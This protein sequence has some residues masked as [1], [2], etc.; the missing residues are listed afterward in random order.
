MSILIRTAMAALVF[1]VCRA[2]ILSA[3]VFLRRISVADG[4]PGN[5]VNVMAQDDK[6]FIWFGTTGGV[7]RYDGYSAVTPHSYGLG[8]IDMNV[9][10][11][12]VSPDNRH[13]S[14]WIKTAGGINLCYDTGRSGFVDYTGRGD[15]DKP[16]A[17]HV[18]VSDGVWLFGSGNGARHVQCRDGDFRVTDYSA[19]G[20]G[21]ADNDVIRVVEDN[22]RNMYVITRRGVTAVT[23]T[24]KTVSLL[25]GKEI[26]AGNS[27]GQKTFFLTSDARFYCYDTHLRLTGKSDMRELARKEI[28][29]TAD[30]VWNG[31]WLVFTKSRTLSV[32]L[33]TGRCAFARNMFQIPGGM[34]CKSAGGYRFVYDRHSDIL[35]FGSGGEFDRV[36]LPQQE[37]GNSQTVGRRVKIAR[38]SNGKFYIATNGDGLYVYEPSEKRLVHHTAR[39]GGSA[40]LSNTLLS[41]MA[42]TDGTVWIGNE[43]AG[44]TCVPSGRKEI[45]TRIRVP[46]HRDNAGAHNLIRYIGKDGN[47][48]FIASGKDNILYSLSLD[49]LKL[50]MT[51]RTKACVYARLKDKYGHVFTG[52]R[53]DGLYVDGVRY[54][55][56]SKGHMIAS[57]HIYD[58]RQ[59]A[60]GRIWIATWGG[61][62]LMT[63]YRNGSPLVFDTF[64][65]G[66]KLRRL[67]IGNDGRMWIAAT[68]GLY[69]ADVSDKVIAGN[70]FR[71][72]S[73][74]DGTFPIND[75]VCVHVSPG[76]AVYAGGV[77]RGLV[78]GILSGAGGGMS[79]TV[80]T[81]ADGLAD[82]NVRSV[83]EDKMGYIWA[84]TE[85]ALSRINMCDS[86]VVN[87]V[88]EGDFA[89]NSY[90]ENAV[91]ADADGRLLFGTGNG[92][93]VV[94]PSDI[95]DSRPAMIPRITN[96]IVNG[97]SVY[98]DGKLSGLLRADGDGQRLVLTHEQNSV[99]LS[100][101]DL[102]YGRS[103][104]LYMYRLDGVDKDWQLAGRI[105][106][107]QYSGLR[108]GR[109]TFLVRS[110]TGDSRW[111][112]ASVL[113]ITVRRPWWSSWW[114]FTLYALSGSSLLAWLYALWLRGY[115]LRRQMSEERRMTEFR[116]GLFTQIA[117]E[118]RTPLALIQGASARLLGLGGSDAT[119]QAVQTVRRGTARLLRQVNQLMEFR[120]V[121]AGSVRLSVSRGDIVRFV[122]D[123]ADDFRAEASGKGVTLSFVALSR[124]HSALFDRRVVETVAYNLLSNAVKYTPSGGSVTVR[125][126]S[127][128]GSLVLSV[129]DS[130][131]GLTPQ[132]RESLFTPFM[133][134]CVSG[135]GMGIGLYT[136]R[137][138]AEAHHGTLSYSAAPGG[139]SV[140]SMAFPAS[141]GAYAP[142]EVSA[143]P[144]AAVPPG[145]SPAVSAAR[146]EDI[147]GM[148]PRPLNGLTVA[149]VEDDPD[150]AAQLRSE[151]GVYFRTVCYSDGP[152]AAA[153]LASD[154]P[155]LVICDVMLPGLDGYG[156]VRSL[157]SSPA[158]RCVPVIMLTSL[159]DDAHQM[160]AYRAGADDYMV[161]P[162]NFG[163]LLAK[164][165]RLI[166]WAER[167]RGVGDGAPERPAGAVVT[168][169]A[170]RKF[171]ESVDNA[172][173][174]NL[175]NPDFSLDIL[176]EDMGMGR[177]KFYG[178]MKEVYGIPP[179]SYLAEYRLT[180]ARKMLDGG[181]M[182]PT[183]VSRKAGFRS[184]S[185]FSQR[186]RNRFGMSPTDYIS[187][188]GGDA[189]N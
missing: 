151:A 34:E 39:S 113:E 90:V 104:S 80:M 141:D 182:K 99:G 134:G 109:Y 77:G 24:G 142:S 165:V 122:R 132:Q 64:L 145:G 184:Y 29:Y 42:S 148:M 62:L 65:S 22:R 23:G 82:N 57:D 56:R 86:S 185:Y 51:M 27:D 98:E 17:N 69:L 31:Q 171:A 54:S 93:A 125:L 32:E 100:F 6:G 177:T 79:T 170:D 159:D 44:V 33:A 46:E 121:S 71:R 11:T 106:H 138:M 97:S 108:P 9:S 53:G 37:T 19:H 25:A 70:S 158:G 144:G 30:V 147:T 127:S 102:S 152:S 179:G 101:S 118:F 187:G 95:S 150:M 181:L 66:K 183:E 14:V 175:G 188:A 26:V 67:C 92:I 16:F 155:A 172:M 111:S 58:I 1:L 8:G 88:D 60:L 76:G 10:I 2:D 81:M 15:Y 139:G 35:M 78:R 89:G 173:E 116:L 63:R 105:P 4:L 74:A 47:G 136:S 36:R 168:S 180:A 96:I 126:S 154:P 43:S 49:S 68:D 117:H 153:G 114:A 140:F 131:P 115:R 75:I 28:M 13:S 120:R 110:M 178:K 48:R 166:G 94:D 157:R 162:C 174:K 164:A 146:T 73:S 20:G 85:T 123:I 128:G 103:G 163:L 38:D 91:A 160:R 137:R 18:I 50:D 156:V 12:S 161:K 112:A 21:L 176:A 5:S 133:H 55:T 129:E 7:C 186:F 149:I 72:F 189:G 169:L 84:G 59:D 130:G 167:A 41:I 52:T 107:A 45:I 3:D 119:R 135:G 143:A 124:S 61:G 87:L 40:V 83:T